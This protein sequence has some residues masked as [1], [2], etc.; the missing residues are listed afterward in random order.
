MPYQKIFRVPKTSRENGSLESEDSIRCLDKNSSRSSNRSNEDKH[1]NFDSC[2]NP[3]K[4]FTV[5]REFFDKEN[6][7]HLQS[8]WGSQEANSFP[9]SI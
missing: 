7:D 6:C 3:I 1:L 8:S 4:K 2:V 5:S 9:K